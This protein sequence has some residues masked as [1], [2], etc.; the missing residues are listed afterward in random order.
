MKEIFSENPLQIIWQ[1]LL[2][3][4]YVDVINNWWKGRGE[5][6][7]N[8]LAFFIASSIQQAKS[9]F[10]SASSAH[11]NILPLLLYY[12]SVNLLVGTLSLVKHKRFN[13]T[14]HGMVLDKDSLNPNDIFSIK[15]IPRDMNGAL[16]VIVSEMEGISDLTKSYKG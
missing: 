8:D 2:R 14:N 13:I 16:N 4:S 15:L 9:Y 10:D 11:N 6:E 5:T 3:F 1:T 12:G 7:E